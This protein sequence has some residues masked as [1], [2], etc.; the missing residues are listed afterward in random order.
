MVITLLSLRCPLFPW[1]RVFAQG[2][3]FIHNLRTLTP[4]LSRRE[5]T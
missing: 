2:K 4:A 1:E 3:G 5:R